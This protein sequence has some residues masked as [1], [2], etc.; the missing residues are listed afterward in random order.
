SAKIDEIRRRLDMSLEAMKIAYALDDEKTKLVQNRLHKAKLLQ[1]TIKPFRITGRVILC[2]D[3]KIAEDLNRRQLHRYCPIYVVEPNER[4]QDYI[5]GYD[6]I[7]FVHAQNQMYPSALDYSEKVIMITSE[8]DHAIAVPE[9]L[10]S[11]YINNYDTIKA[12]CDF[13]EILLELPDGLQ[14]D[15][16]RQLVNL[17]ALREVKKVLSQLTPDGKIAE[18][19]NADLDR[20]SK[21]VQDFDMILADVEIETNEKITQAVQEKAVTIKGEQILRILQAASNGEMDSS[22]LKAYLPTE[23]ADTVME[24]LDEA[25]TLL[26]TRLGLNAK[27]AEWTD[28]IIIRSIGLPI[29]VNK[30][31]ADAL[32][33]TLRQRLTL[34]EY[35]IKQAMAKQLQSMEDTISKAVQAMLEFDFFFGIGLFAKQF[36]LIAPNLDTK[37][38]GIGFVQAKNIFL[39]KEK[40]EDATVP[41]DYVIGEVEQQPQGTAKERVVLLSGAN[42]GGKTC[43]L[44][45]ILQI[46]ILGQS[47]FPVPAKKCEMG[48]FDQLYYYAKSQGML[49]AGA[50][51]TSLRRLAEIILNPSPK[52][53]CFDEWEAA[54]EAEA[55][56]RVVAAAL[57]L[58]AERSKSCVL[59][60]SHLAEQISQITKSKI[61]IDGIEAKG[62][63]EN[64]SLV[65]SRTP[66][67]N[68]LARSMPE[69]IV[70]RLYKTAS[71]QYKTIYAQILAALRHG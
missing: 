34:E 44:Q 45:T 50:F 43:L 32:L 57:D 30:K 71:E 66:R 55:A 35:K 33:N 18:G 16:F 62:L 67:Y 20:F 61:R 25:E 12:S 8:S 59:F 54:T 11:L 64:L 6:L 49:S 21:A 13:A 2:D 51:E 1:T 24:A 38:N 42:S 19:V 65:V 37:Y 7:V 27:E 40:G 41:I 4:I 68:Y 29:R 58:F 47:G 14:I 26:C 10:L 46:L 60:V 28:G 36:S 70:T 53:V 23:I 63:D 31:K 48:V 52:F 9:A 22:R 15:L 39:V 17:D 3:D 69:L 5:N 56:A